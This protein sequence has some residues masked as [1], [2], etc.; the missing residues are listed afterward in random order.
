MFYSLLLFSQCIYLT[1]LTNTSLY[2]L[3]IKLWILYCVIMRH[4]QKL[5]LRAGRH[6]SFL[7]SKQRAQMDE[8][9]A[10]CFNE[11]GTKVKGEGIC[12]CNG[13]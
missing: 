10:I 8:T 2:A 9:A 1:L 6:R 11:G 4:N 5:C 13:M 12:E 3:V 7:Q